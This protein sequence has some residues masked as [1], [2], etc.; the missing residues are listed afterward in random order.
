MVERITIPPSACETAGALSG[1]T[2]THSALCV[3]KQHL[4]V[5][6]AGSLR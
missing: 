5:A 1:P 6:V 2:V 3:E 4:Q